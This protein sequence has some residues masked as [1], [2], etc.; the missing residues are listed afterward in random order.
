MTKT[1]TSTHSSTQ[2]MSKR[3]PKLCRIHVSQP[4]IRSNL[5][6]QRAGEDGYDPAIT[7]KRGGENVYGHEVLIK[8][9]DGNVVAR[10][11]QPRDKRLGC[12]ARIWIESY[13]E[14]EIREDKGDFIE[15]T[16]LLR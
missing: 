5:K 13:A 14:V 15:V 10:V 9:K 1:S 16:E 8:D 6:K 12:G 4:V 2:K 7:V 3:K 11:V